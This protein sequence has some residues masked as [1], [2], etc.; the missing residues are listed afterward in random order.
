MKSR[1]S[2]HEAL[3]EI[4]VE[5]RDSLVIAP[6]AGKSLDSRCSGP[7]DTSALFPSGW[8]PA[9]FWESRYAYLP[10]TAHEQM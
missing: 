8:T 4:G 3:Q 7:P 6:F 5:Q 1:A 2:A 9:R 10:I